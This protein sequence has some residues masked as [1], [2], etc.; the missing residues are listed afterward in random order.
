MEDR[1]AEIHTVEDPEAYNRTQ[2]FREIHDARQRVADAITDMETG[3]R[4]SGFQVSSAAEIG[5]ALAV[6]ITELEPLIRQS[7]YEWGEI[8][9]DDVGYSDLREYRSNL[10]QL[11]ENDKERQAPNPYHAVKTFAAVNR[12]Y[13]DLGMGLEVREDK[14]DAGFDYSDIL[15]DGPPGDGSTPN[16][17][18]AGGSDE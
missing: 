12:V 13:A 14:G 3:R 18:K 15:E 5:K 1:E 9:P 10:G 16:V 4:G 2:R 7:T 8:I 17:G 6:Y 11:K